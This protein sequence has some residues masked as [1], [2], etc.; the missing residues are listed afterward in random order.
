MRNRISW[1]RLSRRLLPAA[2]P[3]LLL[4]CEEPLVNDSYA[5]LGRESIN[6][7]DAF[8]ALLESEVVDQRD[9]R[10]LRTASFTRR[11]REE[12]DLVV[13]FERSGDETEEPYK[14]LEAYLFDADPE[15]MELLPEL[16]TFPANEVEGLEWDSDPGEDP[17][18]PEPEYELEDDNEPVEIKTQIK[19]AL[20]AIPRLLLRPPAE[21]R[22]RRQ[23]EQDRSADESP[24]LSGDFEEERYKTI[25]YFLRD[26]SANLSFWNLLRY[27][28]R[29]HPQHVAYIDLQL[30]QARGARV[31]GAPT[32]LAPLGSRTTAYPEGELLNRLVFNRD[33]FPAKDF[34]PGSLRYPV[35][36]VPESPRSYYGLESEMDLEL[37]PT[38]LLQSDRGE[39]LIR[40][41]ELPRARLILVYN[42]E[43]FL[44]H[45][46]VH[47]PNRELARALVSY[48]L[49]Q[50][51]GGEQP[52]VAAFVRQTL[53]ESEAAAREQPSMLRFL[54]VF[55]VN[56]IV[57]QFLFL[58]VLFL[59][60]RWPHSRRPLGNPDSGSREFLEH[61]R[62]LGIRLS[63]TEKGRRMSALDPL[64][65]Y[66]QRTTG[67]DY[68]PVIEAIARATAR[69][70]A[71]RDMA[72][73]PLNSQSDSESRDESNPYS[74]DK[75]QY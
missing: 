34:P 11:V 14:N 7:L 27:Q 65:K 25:I 51:E 58:L 64:I 50:H 63:R 38:P 32:Y 4:A 54:T 31:A 72:G 36:V 49:R 33:V 52:P 15:D 67:R 22:S 55:P 59:I 47:P 56:L 21:S 19:T 1:H 28:L 2:L 70:T 60:S 75:S 73:R 17:L 8:I 46:Q 24:R 5:S 16:S 9:G 3:A 20:P 62:A 66:K 10:V 71:E 12:S 53:L 61:I 74:K 39:D 30:E 23:Q 43:S 48:A 29:D 45:S 26:T 41:L 69:S 40:E 37:F 44:N 57:I 42:S 35:R 68:R 6:G 13:Y 18:T